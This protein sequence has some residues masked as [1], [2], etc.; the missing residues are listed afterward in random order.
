MKAWFAIFAVFFSASV[1]AGAVNTQGWG[2]TAIAG[3]DPVAYF[4]ESRPVEGSERFSYRW[5]GADW[6]FS[7]AANLERFI[8]TPEAFAPQYGGYCAYAVANGYTAKIDPEAWRIVDG[9]LYLNYSRS[10]QQTWAG[11]IAGYIEKGDRNWPG[12]K[13]GL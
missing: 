6:H 13:A 7:S 10:V 1:A 12:I 2:D 11:D 3:Y 8:A 4:T 9:K 5:E